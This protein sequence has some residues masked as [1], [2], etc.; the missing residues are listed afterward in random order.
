MTAV[1]DR[2]DRIVYDPAFQAAC[3]R[4]AHGNGSSGGIASAALAALG[5]VAADPPVTDEAPNPFRDL[6]N[7]THQAIEAMLYDLQSNSDDDDQ[8]ADWIDQWRAARGEAGMDDW[9]WWIGGTDDETYRLD[10]PTRDQAIAAV[11]HALQHGDINSEDGRFRIVEA[12]CWADNMDEGK[13]EFPFA[14]RRN[15]ETLPIPTGDGN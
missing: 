12:R 10:F 1:D 5:T 11:P 6:R 8:V 15:A 14:D 4:Y 13:D 9:R 3:Q 2:R 7:D